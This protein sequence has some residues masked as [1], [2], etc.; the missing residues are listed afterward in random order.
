MSV[1]I[2]Q[3]WKWP[4]K[5]FPHT[6][7]I[8]SASDETTDRGICLTSNKNLHSAPGGKF[9]PKIALGAIFSLKIGV[10]LGKYLRNQS[11]S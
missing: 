1:R 8:V 7:C 5:T 11:N 6:L 9:G 2:E 3:N 10:L 4:S